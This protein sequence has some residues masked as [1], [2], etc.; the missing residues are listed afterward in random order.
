[1]YELGELRPQALL[2]R[3]GSLGVRRRKQ[4]GGRDLG[5][6]P[7]GFG[8]A[9]NERDEVLLDLDGGE[10]FTDLV[11]RF[12]SLEQVSVTDSS[13]KSEM[14]IV[15]LLADKGFFDSCQIL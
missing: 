3:R 10:V 12:D 2:K 6:E 15:D 5:G 9:D 4:A 11:E 13:R 1:M 7:V 14:V 8:K